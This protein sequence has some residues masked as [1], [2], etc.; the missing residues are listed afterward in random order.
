MDDPSTH[1]T[2]SANPRR[3]WPPPPEV[4]TDN[5]GAQLFRMMQDGKHFPRYVECAGGCGWWIGVGDAVDTATH[6][7]CAEREAFNE[8]L[9]VDLGGVHDAIK[10][11][12]R[13]PSVDTMIRTQD[14]DGKLVS[15]SSTITLFSFKIDDDTW[16]G[17]FP[18]G[19][20]W[21]GVLRTVTRP[22]RW[23][24]L[25]SVIHAWRN[26]PSENDFSPFF[27]AM[28]E[29]VQRESSREMKITTTVRRL[30]PD[31][32]WADDFDPHFDCDPPAMMHR[33]W[34]FPYVQLV[35][36]SLSWH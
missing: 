29:N 23:Y 5:N 9:G 34:T 13:E 18:D 24:R 6:D 28:W 12:M 1:F 33:E 15:I 16:A 7:S 11:Q 36:D 10:A 20:D 2:P 26:P 35:G 22:W 21:R 19:T 25:P 30:G 27:D 17:P 31:S 8:A 3:M 4:E 14:A 32:V